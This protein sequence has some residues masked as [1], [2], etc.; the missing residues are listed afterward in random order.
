MRFEFF[1]E[2]ISEASKRI[3]AYIRMTPLEYSPHLSSLGSGKVYLKLENFQ[4]TGSFKIRGAFNKILSLSE[5]E[6]E[7]GVVTA[8]TG[9][10]G[11]AVAYALQKLKYKGIIFLPE[12]A[13]PAKLEDLKF[14]D[15]ELR[16]HGKDCV[17]TENYARRFAS[18]KGM[19]YLPPYNDVKIVAG[20]GTVGVEIAEQIK[21]VDSVLVPVGGGG[22]VSGIALYLKSINPDIE[23][24]GCQPLNSPV[25]YESI[26]AGKIVE[27]ESKPT[28]SDGTAG[29][30][31]KGAITFEIC[32]KY[33]DDFI[34]V[35]EEEIKNAIRLV[36]EKHHMI[37]EGAAALSVA[38]YLKEKERFMGKKVVLVLSGCRLS[39]NTLK[40]IMCGDK[41]EYI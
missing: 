19:T 21:N 37:V 2:E 4:V 28:L 41:N 40:K 32:Q 25:M 15:V 8:S 33:V 31:E 26:K 9:N 20:Q 6:K 35:T 5:E 16:F 13:S 7:K 30:I 38:S 29:G 34:L 24:I 27:M 22:L 36:V 3:R 17:E 39:S 10:H 18:E 12:N 11:V 14:Y 23:I 1:P